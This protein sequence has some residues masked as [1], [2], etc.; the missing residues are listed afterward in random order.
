MYNFVRRGAY[1]LL[2]AGFTY[3][4]NRE[5]VLFSIECVSLHDRM[6]EREE[7]SLQC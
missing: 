4:T 2:I 7:H 5:C 1:M 3:K 6:N